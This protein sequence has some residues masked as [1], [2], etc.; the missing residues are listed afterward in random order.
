MRPPTTC[1]PKDLHKVIKNFLSYRPRFDLRDMTALEH[2]AFTKEW[3]LI[4]SKE[5]LL[6]SYAR[7][8]I[9]RI[10]ILKQRR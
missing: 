9:T 7:K 5:S 1:N 10:M 4:Q 6:P 8:R 2:Y 3:K